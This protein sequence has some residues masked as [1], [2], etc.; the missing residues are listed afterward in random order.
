MLIPLL[1]L[2]GI[3]GLDSDGFRRRLI[4]R[5]TGGPLRATVAQGGRH[6]VGFGA[7][8]ASRRRPFLAFFPDGARSLV[9]GR[10]GR[11]PVGHGDGRHAGRLA[12][13]RSM[14]TSFT[15]FLRTAPG[16][17]PVT[18]TGAVSVWDVKKNK[19]ILVSRRVSCSLT[20]WRSPGTEKPWRS[21]DSRIID[22][23]GDSAAGSL[24]LIEVPSAALHRLP[25]PARSLVFSPDGIA[26]RG[27]DDTLLPPP[28]ACG[29]WLPANPSSG[30]AAGA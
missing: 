26:S 23:E 21:A 18:G 4:G 2:A 29:R 22:F 17:P 30:R 1:C 13:P 14:G 25:F 7:P 12:L 5:G 15:P 20:P 27:G 28:S 9:R 24:W 3:S 19:E 16:S 8:A 6:A 10:R 11:S